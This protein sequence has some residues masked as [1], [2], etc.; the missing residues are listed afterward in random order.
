MTLVPGLSRYDLEQHA[1]VR[2]E[3]AD[4]TLPHTITTRAV[5]LVEV[6]SYNDSSYDVTVSVD[7]LNQ[8]AEG[9][10]H[11]SP[12]QPMT[13]GPVLRVSFSSGGNAANTQLADSLCEYSQFVTLARQLV[14]PQL[15]AQVATAKTGRTPPDI[16]HITSCRAGVPIRIESTQEVRNLGGIPPQ[17]RIDEKAT[18]Q[19]AGIL[20]R[21]SITIDGFLTAEGT[22]SFASGS[23]LPS[24]VQSSSEGS[25]R[26]GLG[27][28]TVTFKQSLTQQLRR[29]ATEVPN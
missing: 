23:R 5:L 13:L 21:D 3:G 25:I 12:M 20:Q 9:F 6:L 17:V 7:S 29:R 8:V 22:A 27:D 1:V 15:P 2:L 18:L 10:G 4:D 19:G 16:M 11:P 26:I 14:L 24:I 28:S